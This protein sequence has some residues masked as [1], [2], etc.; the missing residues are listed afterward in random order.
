MAHRWYVFFL[1][2]GLTYVAP[3]QQSHRWID[4]LSYRRIH[5][6]R[7]AGDQLMG[8]AENAVF[9]T[10]VDP[11]DT[12]Y[13]KFSTIQGLSGLKLLKIG[14]APDKQWLFVA[15]EKGRV[16][17]IDR[18]SGE[19]YNERGLS[20]APIS[21]EQKR[22]KAVDYAE[23][24]FYLAMPYGVTEYKTEPRGFGDTYRIGTDGTDI[25]V[26]DIK[27]FDGKIFAA[28]S[29]NG[30]KYI[31]LDDPA[32]ANPARWIRLGGGNWY[33]LFVIGGTLYGLQGY[34]LFKLYPG[35]LEFVMNLIGTPLAVASNGHYWSVAYYNQVLIYDDAF[36]LVTALNGANGWR[37][38]PT[39]LDMDGRYV[40]VG[41]QK[42][43]ILQ[44]ELGTGE[45][46][47]RFPE[48]PLMNI[49]FAVDAYD[50]NV[51]IVY[52]D[53]DELYNPYPLDRRGISHLFKGRWYNIPYSAFKKV[54]LTD[55]KINRRDT[56]QVFIGSFHN[57]LLEF[58]DGRLVQTYDTA[59]STIQPIDLN[60]TPFASYRISPLEFDKDN[61]L[62][63]FQGLVM[64]EVHRFDFERGEWQ[65]YS[66][67]QLMETA[68]NEGAAD[69]H[70]D[71]DGYLW[72]A[73]HR[74]G[75][76][77][78][79]PATGR[80][81]A[82]NEANNIPYEG[83]YRNTQAAAV[84]KDNVLWIGTFRGLRIL[85]NPG[86]AFADPHI[87]TQPVIIELA[88]L[89]GQDNQGVELMADQE[90]T[91]IVV[92]GSN[93]KWIG[94]ANAGVF[95]FTE[96]GQKTIYHFT[97]E[98]SP[99][100]GNA[101]YD[102]AVDPVTGK[103]YISTDRG[104]IGFK[105]DATE[106]KS[107]LDR[108]YVYPNPVNQKRHE[109]LVIRNLI[110]GIS[111]K[112]TDIEGNLVYETKS[113]GGTVDWDLRNF[114]GRKV[115]TGVYLILLSDTERQHTKVLKALIVK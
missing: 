106:G 54:S 45:H 36:Q 111:V 61:R 86:R 99:L 10:S 96:D 2:W 13:D 63:M 28:T 34:K 5:S 72:I 104:L 9:F 101:I 108:A 27:I 112:I 39:S 33:H 74:L 65:A 78:L 57:G 98:N 26:N 115:A 42:Q 79:D 102:I 58:R 52:G 91:E 53:Y 4:L 82:L 21:D 43:G 103:V 23:G 46:T 80:L 47:W 3:G 19:V 44:Y 68:Y 89:H 32:K 37:I 6:I 83:A 62:W 71:R 56:S 87:Q 16:E 97:A 11:R 60:G 50:D 100:P 84:D 85:R 55:V 105:G 110:S 94:T 24:V 114:D 70:F 95:Y 38:F 1:F 35:P 25:A 73:T 51:W 77:G 15:H 81:V 49:P 69:M 14:Y 40:Y 92:D 22:V 12:V 48:G 30:V 109:R 88:E 29:G 107:D 41:T 31:D 67:D 90:I 93:N 113:K 66:F 76:V 20:L 18:S 17:I 7:V 64:D 59:N 8:G 75:L